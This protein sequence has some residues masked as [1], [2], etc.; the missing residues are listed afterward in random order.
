MNL[1]AFEDIPWNSTIE[2]Y[3]NAIIKLVI[4]NSPSE[5]TVQMILDETGT[6]R[7]TFYRYFSDKFELMNYVYY[8][9]IR[10]LLDKLYTSMSNYRKYL[11]IMF[12]ILQEKNSYYKKLSSAD[13][14]NYFRA[15][16][17]EF[18]PNTHK[19]AFVDY[20]G[21][22]QW[23]KPMEDIIKAYASGFAKIVFEWQTS[24]CTIYTPEEMA[25][26]YCRRLPYEMQQMLNKQ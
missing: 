14:P 15:F 16:L 18:W 24:D 1:K 5:V 2:K 9:D 23:D 25:D 3:Y 12:E 21:K 20:Y 8:H 19:K 17:E 7:P 4:E 26:L 22:E 11:C 10:W 13:E 6:S